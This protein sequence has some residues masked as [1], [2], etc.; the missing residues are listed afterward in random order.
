MRIRRQALPADFLPVVRQILFAQPALEER[1][2]IHARGRMRLEEH[3]IAAVGMI[4]AAKEM[5]EAT[6]EDLGRRRV[7]ADVAAEL[8]VRNVGA[9][10][11][12]QRIPAHNRSDPLFEG[13]IA[14]IFALLLTRDRVAVRRV[15][16]NVG[17]DT[18]LLRLLL[19]QP[20]QR[21]RPVLTGDADDGFEGV[22]PLLRFDRVGVSRVPSRPAQQ[23]IGRFVWRVHG[24]QVRSTGKGSSLAFI[25]EIAHSRCCVPVT[26]RR[27]ARDDPLNR[28]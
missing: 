24:S 27:P 4:H 5:I 23:V 18:Q 6:L 16:R 17:D 26:S 12:G 2:C 15:R 1:A 21:L 22:E 10:D 19:E 28:R 9:D 7:A 13:E 25:V 14:G 20:Q 8:A 3:E 11:H